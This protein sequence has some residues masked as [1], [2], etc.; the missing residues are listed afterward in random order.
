MR[1]EDNYTRVIRY[2][3]R[4]SP[5][6]LLFEH[7]PK[8]GGTTIVSKIL[9]RYLNKKVFSINTGDI[10]SRI[11]EFKALSLEQRYYYDF[12]HGHG[13]DQLREYVHE[14]AVKVTILRDP[15]ER[16]ISHYYYVLR[17]PQHHLYKL[18]TDKNISLLE[19]ATSDITKEF[20][21][22]YVTRFSRIESDAVNKNPDKAILEAYKIIKEEYDFVG[23]VDNLGV[24]IRRISR[25]AEFKIS[26][27]ILNYNVTKNRP[28]K[29]EIDKSVIQEIEEANQVDIKFYKLVK[30]M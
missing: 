25:I 9:P 26:G 27:E 28:K 13:A 7:I 2:L 23:F 17:S 5:K 14:D 30:E 10:A 20:S 6:K 29:D 24:A 12:V 18:V 21:N 3:F 16:I 11:A 4:S 8:C 15:V 1:L 19:Y 22:N